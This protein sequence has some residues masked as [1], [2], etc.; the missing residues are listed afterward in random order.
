MYLVAPGHTDRHTHSCSGDAACE[1]HTK[2]PPLANF[3]FFANEHGLHSAVV[4]VFVF[5]SGFFSVWSGESEQS[6]KSQRQGA[7][8]SVLGIKLL[9]QKTEFK[10]LHREKMENDM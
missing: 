2:T 9:P 3:I 6:Q 7:S 4:W 1:I 10:F 5:M 8:V